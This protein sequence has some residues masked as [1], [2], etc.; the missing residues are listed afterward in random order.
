MKAL[1][2][3]QPWA[4]FVTWGEKRVETRG[5]HTD[6]TGPLAIHASAEMPPVIR[7]LVAETPDILAILGKHRVSLDALPR[8]AIIGVVE[9]VTIV[10]VER[11]IRMRH[12]VTP[13][14]QALGDYRP[15]RHAWLLRNAVALRQPVPAKGMLSLWETGAELD[16]L[17]MAELRATREQAPVATSGGGRRR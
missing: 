4:S 8:G 16:A 14:E 2:L 7:R 12:V 10:E 9:L 13:R 17:V 6:Y 3:Q 1:S 15:R 5:W 11:A